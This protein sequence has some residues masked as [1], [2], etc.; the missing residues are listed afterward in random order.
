MSSKRSTTRKA[1]AIGLGIVGIAGLSLASAAQLNLGASTLGAATNLVASCQP[2]G[3]ANAI[4]VTYTHTF[5]TTGTVG[6]KVNVVGLK[7]VDA[8]CNGK[9]VRVTLLGAADTNLGEYTGTAGTGTS[10]VLTGPTGTI[11][12]DAVVK[13]AVVIS[14]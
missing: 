3:V 10:S 14:D 7:G 11:A 6:Y 5:N 2:A 13:V 8:A 1:A 4:S 12:G 9:A